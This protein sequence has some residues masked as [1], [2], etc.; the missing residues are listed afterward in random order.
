MQQQYKLR[1]APHPDTGWPKLPQQTP[2]LSLHLQQQT[3]GHVVIKATFICSYKLVRLSSAFG[4]Q[5]GYA[6]CT[7]CTEA[8]QVPLLWE[9]H[10]HL[11]CMQLTLK[12]SCTK[13]ASSYIVTM[14]LPPHSTVRVALLL[15]ACI[16]H[17]MIFSPFSGANLLQSIRWF[18]ASPSQV[19]LQSTKD[20]LSNWTHQLPIANSSRA[21]PAAV[22]LKGTN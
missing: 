20:R 15:P 17:K 7:L 14:N 22:L 9:T 8:I 3:I 4:D 11:S 2:V 18:C 10:I 12:F 1:R 16:N 19:R 13:Q 6:G 5:A 21:N